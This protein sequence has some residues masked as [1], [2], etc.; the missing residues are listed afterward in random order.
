[1]GGLRRAH[2]S[3][4][5]TFFY[6]ALSLL[7]HKG[8]VRTYAKILDLDTPYKNLSLNSGGQLVSKPDS[9]DLKDNRFRPDG[10][11]FPGQMDDGFG[12]IGPFGDGP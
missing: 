2:I 8:E 4:C 5:I 3:D 11:T 6:Q 1:M 12:G 10:R 7:P 9:M